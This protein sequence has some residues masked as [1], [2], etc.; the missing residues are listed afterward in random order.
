VPQVR[1]SF[2]PPFQT[3]PVE[4][5]YA[6]E[7]VVLPVLRA[8]AALVALGTQLRPLLQPLPTRSALQNVPVSVHCTEL[9]VAVPDAV[10]S[11][12]DATA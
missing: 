11:V 9:G 12:K 3:A 8:Q 4:A 5:P 2:T 10:Q 1:V 7:Q 6:P